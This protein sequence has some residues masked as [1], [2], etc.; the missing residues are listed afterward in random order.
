ME[1]ELKRNHSFEVSYISSEQ[2]ECVSQSLLEGVRNVAEPMNT[3]DS[4]SV[5]YE[6]ELHSAILLQCQNFH[7]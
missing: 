3:I 5:M 2:V 7:S 4:I 1:E 6:S